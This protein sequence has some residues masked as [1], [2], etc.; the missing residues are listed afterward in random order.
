MTT[1]KTLDLDAFVLARGPAALRCP[2]PGTVATSKGDEQCPRCARVDAW[3]QK[4][5]AA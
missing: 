5:G 4:A 1:T 3:L 2:S